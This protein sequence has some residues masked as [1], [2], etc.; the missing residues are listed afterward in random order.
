MEKVFLHGADY[1]YEQWLDRK[2]ILD[3]DLVYMKEVKANVMSVGIF[4][5]SMIESEEGVFDYKWLEELFDKLYYNGQK[6]IFATPSGSKPAWLSKKYPEV[7]QMNEDGVRQQHG[8]RHNHCRS[9]EVYREKCVEMNTFL[10]KHFGKHPALYMW[11]VSNEYNGMSCYCPTCIY[12]FQQW[13]KKKYKTLDALNAAWWTTFWSHRFSSWSEIFPNDKSIQ[14]MMLDWQRFTSELTIDFFNEECKPLRRYT[15]DVPIT[16]NFQFPDVGLDYHE[17][18]KNVDVVSWDSYPD[19]HKDNTEIDVAVKTAFM[20]DL[21]RSY[22][23][24]PFLLMESTPSST[25]WKPAAKQK[26]PG[27]HKLASL[28]AIAHG[29]DSV[30]Y[31]QW[32]QSRGGTEKFHSAVVSHIGT[33]NTRIFNDVKEVGNI[34][35][36]LSKTTNVLGVVDK[37]QVAIVYDFQNGW[38]INDSELPRN[39]RK[40]Y[41]EECIKHYKA[42]WKLGIQ[43]DIIDGTCDNLADYKLVILPMLYM[44]RDGV[45]EKIRA[46]VLNG[47]TVVANFLTGTVNETDLCYLGGTPGELTDVFGIKVEQNGIIEDNENVQVL[48]SA[49]NTK[50]DACD[51]ADI[52]QMNGAKVHSTFVGSDLQDLPAVTVNNFSK[53][54]AWYIAARMGENFLDCFYKNICTDCEIKSVVDFEIPFGVSVQKRGD[55]LFIMNF[56]DET[57]ELGN[58]QKIEPLGVII[59]K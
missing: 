20:H 31:F 17:F 38:A 59:K 36:D 30:Q 12:N 39:N 8:Y 53:G 49:E 22:K 26:K 23:R 37:S 14:G 4:S 24:K 11:H 18:A 7:C 55:V 54:N 58:G 21:N 19:W 52:I 34:L 32:R 28:Q 13:L 35:D 10:A 29:S 56:T 5:W 48:C 33:N 27:M 44:F 9:S 43:C 41:Q 16:T 1:N 40:Q 3:T 46:Y 2:D 57:K 50:F 25:N 6:I 42:F 45:P 47:G 51:Y 15:P